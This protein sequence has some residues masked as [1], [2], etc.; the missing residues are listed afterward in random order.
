MKAEDPQSKDGARSALTLQMTLSR[1][2]IAASTS[3]RYAQREG[4]PQ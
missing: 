3:L 1:H 2:V 4:H